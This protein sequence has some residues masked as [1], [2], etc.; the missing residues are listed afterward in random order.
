MFIVQFLYAGLAGVI[1][2]EH[3]ADDY[4]H[5]RRICR[6]ATFAGSGIEGDIVRCL[7]LD[8]E[9]VFQ[10]TIAGWVLVAPETR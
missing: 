8:G 2:S 3:T 7:T 9:L 5:V 1:A 6:R 4:D 10:S